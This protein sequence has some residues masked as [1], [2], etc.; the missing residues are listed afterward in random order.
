M[1]GNGLKLHQGMFRLYIRKNF[2]TERV[3]RHWN[4]L[5]SEVVAF[6][7]WR[8]LKNVHMWHFGTWFSRHGGVGLM[9]GLDDVRRLFQP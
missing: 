8:C 7:P 1:R 5:P 3:V 2:F 6:H 4:R 9:A